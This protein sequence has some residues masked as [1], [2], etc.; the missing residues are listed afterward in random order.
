MADGCTVGGME[1]TIA[2]WGLIGFLAF[3]AIGVLCMVGSWCVDSYDSCAG[4]A[5]PARAMENSSRSC[6][7]I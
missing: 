6:G 5:G 2:M 4:G 3:A 1:N 7:R